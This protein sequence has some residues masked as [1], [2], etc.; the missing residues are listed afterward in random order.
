MIFDGSLVYTPKTII[1]TSNH[2][3]F[4]QNESL[5][6]STDSR[7]I[8]GNS[9]FIALDGENFDAFNFISDELCSKVQ[10]V[11]YQHT[12]QRVATIERLKVKFK[13]VVFIGVENSVK[14]LQQLATS[15]LNFWKKKYSGKVFTITGS[16]GKTTNKDMI[17]HILET[18]FPGEIHST[19]KNFNN[20]IGVPLT[21]FSLDKSHRFLV[22]EIGTNH[23][24]E[25]ETLC[26][27]T[28]PT[29]GYITNI[30]DSHLEFFKNRKNVFKEKI[31]LFESC[32]KNHNVE[33][34]FIIN[35]DD[36][37]LKDIKIESF[38]RTCGAD[39]NANYCISI[40]NDSVK[41]I[42]DGEQYTV[43]NK[44]LLGRH[45]YQNLAMA[46]ALLDGYF[47]GR[48]V[49]ILAAAVKFRPQN[50]RSQFFVDGKQTVF[51]DAYNAN[52]T[53]MEV[54]LN[55]FIEY[56][57]V[58]GNCANAIF[59]LGDM[60]ELGEYTNSA[61]ENLGKWVV[62]NIVPLRAKT[63]FIGRHAAS[64]LS[65]ITTDDCDYLVDTYESRVEF[66][67]TWSQIRDNYS[68]LFIKA[69][70]SLQLESLLGIR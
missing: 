65:G 7:D 70:R 48:R 51:L 47:S 29:S 12:T 18:L 39:S 4:L 21:I 14:Y 15:N 46:I 35:T 2:K 16:N 28:S 34:I 68:F 49:D 11:V 42:F 17:F 26:S 10:A 61:H 60:N 52:P 62:Q 9:I 32:Y 25:I 53:S 8:T 54:S 64:F 22:L 30:G 66:A 40:K 5:E 36:E 56:L 27:I 1:E 63:I 31:S 58:D 50:N 37:L 3:N 19:W 44:F 43:E 20:H 69:S 13:N 33:D 6:V 67:K 23:P 24:G 59:I 57:Q 55:S 41:M 45:N 38:C